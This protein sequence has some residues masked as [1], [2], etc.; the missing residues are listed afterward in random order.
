MSELVNLE[1]TVALTETEKGTVVQRPI[2]VVGDSITKGV[3]FDEKRGRHVLLRGQDFCSLVAAQLKTAVVNLSKFGCVSTAAKDILK[4]RLQKDPVPPALV[5]LELGGN[6]CDFDW[7]AIAAAPEQEHF[8]KTPLEQYEQT[9]TDMVTAA[10]DAGS[11]PVLFNLPP[12]DADKYFRYFTG[13]NQEKACN[14]LKWLGNV[15]RIYWWHERY[16]AAAERVAQAT[17]TPLLMIRS[18]LLSAW[19][20]RRYVSGDGMHPNAEGHQRMAEV[21]LQYIRSYQPNL[22]AA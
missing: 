21:V 17:K 11:Q 15:G 14:I 5:A 6:D 22:L 16:N 18:A 4:D 19:D 12:I 10:Y 2:L 1:T 9:L 3:I 8:P 13:G 7:N 20:Y